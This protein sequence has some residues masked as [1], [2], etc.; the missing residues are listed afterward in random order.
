MK[1]RLAALG[2]LALALAGCHVGAQS[3][4]GFGDAPV[5]TQNKASA[6]II[7][8]PDTYANVAFKCYGHDGI[9]VVNEGG[10]QVPTVVANDPNCP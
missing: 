9:Y 6:A 8:F 7:N 1:K 3:S 5:G 2:V 10:S 4:K